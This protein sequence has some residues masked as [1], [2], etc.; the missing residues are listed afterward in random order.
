MTW[1]WNKKSL[2]GAVGGG[3][4]ISWRQSGH[5]WML[6]GLW[7]AA[8]LYADDVLI[9]SFSKGSLEFMLGQVTDAF[10]DVA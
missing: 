8:I 2:G 3:R 9:I 5:G 1:P 10:R 7:L 4:E 6:D